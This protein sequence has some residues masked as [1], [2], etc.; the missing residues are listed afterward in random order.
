MNKRCYELRVSG[1]PEVAGQIKASHLQRV[2]EALAKTAH[3]ATRLLATGAGS[4][5]GRSPRWLDAAVDFTVTGL[6]SGSTVIAMEAPRLADAAPDSFSQGDF[7]LLEP[8]VGPEDT[9][10]DVASLA[11][12]E[13]KTA[14]SPG[15]R[16]DSSVLEAILLFQRASG[17]SD[18]RYELIPDGSASPHASFALED[19]TCERIRERASRIPDPKAVVVTGVLDEIKHGAGRFRLIL[20][21]GSQILGRVGSDSLV[22]S[23]RSHWGK[24]ATVAGRV[25]FKA[26]G[27]P[28]LI[29]ARRISARTGGDSVF[30]ELPA[31]EPRLALDHSIPR[32]SRR[33]GFGVAGL[34]GRWP[35]DET[36]EELMD[37]LD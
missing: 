9:A 17:V 25:H 33:R 4:G 13:A 1:L 5:R 18:A 3:R 12:E 29:E 27:Q 7:W 37:Q 11:I 19:S 15:N 2:V 31:A 14:D 8:R 36:I 28:R 20:G 24:P 32:R 23:L 34:A 10:L 21:D 22:E 6:R 26:N 30:C 16:F 35:G